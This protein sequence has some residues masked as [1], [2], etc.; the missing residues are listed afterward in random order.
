VTFPVDVSQ[1]NCDKPYSFKV[2]IVLDSMHTLSLDSEFTVVCQDNS[3][4]LDIGGDEVRD[5]CGN[6][7]W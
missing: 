3:L 6:S 5:F 4:F 1:V 2:A 7:F